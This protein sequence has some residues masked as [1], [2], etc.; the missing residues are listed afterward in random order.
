MSAPDALIA[1]KPGDVHAAVAAVAEAGAER[2]LSVVAGVT[3][4]ALE[5]SEAPCVNLVH[6]VH[7]VLVQSGCRAAASAHTGSSVVMPASRGPTRPSWPVRRP[8][9]SSPTHPTTCASQGT[10]PD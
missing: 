2:A 4:S 9:W 7:L 1:V 3:T 10:F 5:E 8:T 6:L